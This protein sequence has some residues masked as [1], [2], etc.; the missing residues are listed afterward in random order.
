MLQSDYYILPAVKRAAGV[1]ADVLRY[2]LLACAVMAL[3]EPALLL[4]RLPMAG[5]LCGMVSSFLLQWSLAVLLLLAAWCHPVLLA[6]QGVVLTRW[7][8][9][10]GAML[11]PLVPVCWV[12][13]LATGEL[14]LYRQ[15]ELP[16]I[17]GIILVVTSLI[18]IPKMAAAPWS[19]QARVV[20]LPILLLVAYSC[21][22]PGLIMFSVVCKLLAAWLAARPLRQLAYLAPRIISMP[23]TD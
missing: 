11:S 22:I 16:L 13:S 3:A 23:E 21:D 17:L 5:I 6:G 4:L 14:L 9:R 10:L 19:L 18:N 8:V 20:A 1:V 15:A 12:Y 2:S 7:L